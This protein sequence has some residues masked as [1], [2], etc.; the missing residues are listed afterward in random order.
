M[1]PSLAALTMFSFALSFLP[2]W[3][4]PAAA[5]LGSRRRWAGL[6][7][8]QPLRWS[9]V[10]LALLTLVLAGFVG[11]TAQHLRAQQLLAE[12][13][14]RLQQS[15]LALIVSENLRQVLERAQLM[16]VVVQQGLGTGSR[17]WQQQLAS[18]VG[19][20]RIFLRTAVFDAQHRPVMGT[21]AQANP[22]T[23]VLAQHPGLCR[24]GQGALVL[25]PQLQSQ[26]Q[27]W[28]LPVWLC[29]A[30]EQGAVSGY[31]LLHMDIGYFLGLYQDV[32]LGAS[33]MLH[34]LTADGR[35]VVAMTGGGLLAQAPGQHVAA[36]SRL[37]EGA[38][39][40]HTQAQLFAHSDGARLANFQRVPHM[41]VT[42]LVSR[43]WT[44]IRA[45]HSAHARRTWV[46]LSAIC[47]L[48]LVGAGV[49]WRTMHRRQ[50]LFEAL[51]RA[52][53]DKQGLIAQLE[54]E[55]HRALELA[56]TDHLTG[57]YNRRM[58]HE[59]VNSHLALAQRS[60]KHYAL[61]YLD[62]D[63]FKHI[64]DT[65]GHHVGD[66]LL[67]A[68]AQRLRHSLRSSD[69]IARMGGDEFAVLV[70]AMEAPGDVEAL[71][72]KLL[73]VLGAPYEGLAA[74]GLYAS[75]SV[76]IALF[77]QDGHDV[78]VLCR[79][80]DAAMYASKKAGRNRYTYYDAISNLDRAR[81]A[82]LVHQ[83]PAAIAQNQLVLHFQP[84]VC[85]KDYRI[86]GM[87][88]LVR[89]QHPQHGLIFPGDFIELA[90]E[91]GHI[92]ALGDWVMQACCRQIAMWRMQGVQTV[93]LAFNV[94]PLQ[95]RAQGFVQR[96]AG[97]LKHYGVAGH[98]I[99]VEITESSLVESMEQARTVLEQL[100]HMGISI[101]LDDFGTGFSSLNRLRSL[102]IST[103]KLDRSFVNELRTSKEAGVLVTSII[104]L[105]HNLKMQVVAEGVELKD[106]LVFLK[107]AHCDV[108]QGYFL[109]RPVPVQQAQDMLQR[110]VLEPA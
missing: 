67:Q 1:L 18:M 17:F 37:P 79:H 95:L 98:E 64:N 8:G 58:F 99:E 35:I 30:D 82:Q 10:A 19:R 70:T 101:G 21:L 103:I 53:Q 85:L 14:V 107:T 32:D 55:K 54:S 5:A 87:E 43:E 33:G 72:R 59:L 24:A 52:D 2:R 109:G 74:E 36:L 48:A 80:A 110:G 26:E 91:H 97:Y 42:V 104:I 51:Q 12:Q 88:A 57:L 15:G 96:M 71:A 28:Q 105:A 56:A 34:L 94:S 7:L 41:P 106:Q 25:S 66:T 68:V 83:L 3:R 81:Q 11:L 38:G 29:L 39:E 93:P 89:W 76:G 75:P 73:S 27:A 50:E 31:L 63:R 45:E 9:W 16:A 84:K 44:E 23:Q 13:A 92:A 4:M 20:D 40:L 65:F 49:L 60:S 47:V 108:V 102:P 77:P 100:K 62:L 86:V 69:I 6:R 90:E 22:V 61:L 78:E 46:L